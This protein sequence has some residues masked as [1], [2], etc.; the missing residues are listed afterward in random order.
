MQKHGP[1]GESEDWDDLPDE[2]G[3]DDLPDPWD[4]DHSIEYWIWDGSQLIPATC[5]EVARIR[6]DEHTREMFYRLASLKQ[7]ERR[8]ARSLKRRLSML[9]GAFVDRM[10]RLRQT[11]KRLRQ[12]LPRRLP[13]QQQFRRWQRR[14][15][16]REEAREEKSS[17]R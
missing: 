7:G 6:E 13:L 14:S 9:R 12:Q 2:D 11:F 1:E 3:W 5:E 4:G 8:E 16:L 17:R 15:L 10:G